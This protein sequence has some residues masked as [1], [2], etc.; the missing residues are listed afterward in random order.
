VEGVGAERLPEQRPEHA[1]PI[2]ERTEVGLPVPAGRFEAGHL[3][4]RETGQ[5]RTDDELR[6]DLE[7]RRG[8]L[9]VA[10]DGPAEGAVAVA[11]VGEP[12]LVEEIGQ[13]QQEAVADVTEPR[14]VG[15]G[16]A[17]HEPR[18]FDEVVSTGDQRNVAGDLAW[19]HAAVRI[20]HHDDVSSRCGEPRLERCALAARFLVDHDDVGTCLRRRLHRPV[21]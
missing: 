14:D 11:Q 3:G 9:E 5:T 7:P 18:A 1:L 10:Q 8:E 20:Q 13:V 12:G 15:G 17:R 2:P 21:G 19:M 16:G 6:L 4:D